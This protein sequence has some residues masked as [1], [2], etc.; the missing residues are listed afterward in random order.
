MTRRH[1]LPDEVVIREGDIG[2]E[3]FLISEG[4][5]KVD[6]GGSEV[7]RLGA[8][9]FFGELALLSGNPR[10]ATVIA[11]AAARNLCARRSRFPLGDQRQR[12]L[13]RPAAPRLLPAALRPSGWGPAR[14]RSS[15]P[16]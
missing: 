1:Y 11:A 8:G 16:L 9:D 3:L 13:P 6:R 2:H 10:N 4:E 14:R 5:V 12:Q 15:G 7:A